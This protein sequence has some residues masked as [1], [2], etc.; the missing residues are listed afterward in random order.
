MKALVLAAA[1][2]FSATLPTTL[3]VRC[4]SDSTRA[5]SW[6]RLEIWFQKKSVPWAPPWWPHY[7]PQFIAA[8][9]DSSPGARVAVAIPDT[10][11]F[12]TIVPRV[13]GPGGLSCDGNY[14]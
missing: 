12:G 6:M 14:R 1:I 4:G 5:H 7:A 3:A 10:F 2:T 9:R 11:S 8:S 13:R